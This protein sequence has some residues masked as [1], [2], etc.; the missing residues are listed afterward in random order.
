M[1]WKTMKRNK[2][3]IGV[4]LLL[5]VIITQ[6]S[7]AQACTCWY[8]TRSLE[9]AVKDAD[10]IFHGIVTKQDGLSSKYSGSAVIT[11]FTVLDVIKNKNSFIQKKTVKVGPQNSSSQCAPIYINEGEY[12]VYAQIRGAKGHPATLYN[13]TCTNAY[14]TS[15]ET[16]VRSWETERAH[17]KN[18]KGQIVALFE[19]MNVGNVIDLKV[20]K[21]FVSGDDKNI[22]GKT[23]TGKIS[24]LLECPQS[25]L[26][27]GEK[28]IFFLRK[29]SSESTHYEISHIDHFS[30]E[31]TKHK[32]SCDSIKTDRSM[33]RKIE[34]AKEIVGNKK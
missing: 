12:L 30:L 16:D 29:T 6:S 17:N 15:L 20:I 5:V 26:Q 25:P 19:I 2:I 9:Q 1:V 7:A 14:F 23:L 8:K 4:F 27:K 28:A 21:T 18:Y 31:K 22:T 34:K 13:K 11:H 32:F 10:V 33:A 3:V 24:N